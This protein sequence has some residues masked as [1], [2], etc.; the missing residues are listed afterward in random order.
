MASIINKYIEFGH[1]LSSL[2]K[3]FISALARH[4]MIMSLSHLRRN[5]ISTSIW[6]DMTAHSPDR[7]TGYTTTLMPLLEELCGIAEDIHRNAHPTQARPDDSM[8]IM[9]RASQLRSRVQSWQWD[10]QS[11]LSEASA[12]RL[13]AHANA[14]RAAALLMLFR[15][16][17]PAGSSAE[18]DQRALEMA[19]E[20]MMHLRGPP[21]DLRLSAWPALIASC[22]LQSEED[23]VV[24]I[25][26]FRSI[27]GVR[28]TGTS[29]QTLKF[30]TDRVW[31]ARDE[32]CDWN[33]MTLSQQFPG[34][35]VPI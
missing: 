19:E 15:L 5:S 18:S 13:V 2:S 12:E 24:A 20:V 9:Y 11:G 31:R 6:I 27:Y 23:R 22:E 8:S 7:F 21:E 4:D 34:E 32:G 33:W 35:C 29:L 17:Y 16:Q 1:V 30:L 3:Y 25:N 14:Y 26:I 28:K 10:P